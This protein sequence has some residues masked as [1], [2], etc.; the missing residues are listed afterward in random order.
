MSPAAPRSGGRHRELVLG[1]NVTLLA[2]TGGVVALLLIATYRS[3]VLWLVPLLV[4]AFADRIAAVIGAAVA[5]ATGWAG[6][7]RR[8]ES[9]ACWCSA[10]GPTR[11]VVDFALSGRVAAHQ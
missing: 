7:G 6:T 11:A 4:I 3:P 5:E 8:R 2:V 1:A 9:P 10:Q